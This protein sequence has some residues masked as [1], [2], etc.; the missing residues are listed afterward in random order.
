VTAGRRLVAVGALAAAAALPAPAGAGGMNR[1]YLV[2]AL[3]Q[4]AGPATCFPRQ[5]ESS[6]TFD[7]IVL[8][9]PATKYAPAGKPSFVLDVRGVK[10]ASGA[11]VD[12]NVTLHVLTGRISVPGIGTFPDDAV[13]VAPVAVALKAGKRRFAYSPAQASPN[14]L[15]VNGGGVEVLDPEGHRLAVTGSQ[16]KP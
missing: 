10:N 11:L 7:S 4:C 2:P 15:I 8:L 5:L 9:T 12:G 1:V 13:L 16:S 6:Y 3:K 14:G